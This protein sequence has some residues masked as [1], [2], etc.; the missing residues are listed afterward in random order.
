MVVKVLFVYINTDLEDNARIMEFFG[1]KKEELPAVRL[2]SLEEDMTKFRP[3]WTEITAENVL[4]LINNI[5]FKLMC[6]IQVIKFTS[7][8]VEGKL[9]PH[10]MSEEIPS[11]WDKNPVKVNLIL[12]NVSGKIAVEIRHLHL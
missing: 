7:D 4:Q 9:K 1:L 3:D 11:D 2:I 8:Y 12:I 10:L 5:S 6:Y